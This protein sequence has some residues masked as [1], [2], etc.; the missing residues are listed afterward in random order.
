[1]IQQLAE[2]ITIHSSRLKA[3]YQAKLDMLGSLPPPIY[4]S[5]DLRNSGFKISVVDTNLFP[6]GFN[7]LCETFSE[8]ASET[9]QNYFRHWYPSTKKILIFPEEHTRNT[10]YWKN[11]FALQSILENSEFEVQIGS[12]STHFTSD[13][14]VITL[15]GDHPKNQISVRK[16]SIQDNFLRTNDFVPDI[17][18]INNDLS[19]GTPDYLKNIHQPLLPSPHLG[20]HQRRK[21]NHFSIY[22]KLITETSKIMEIDSWRLSPLF[23]METGIDLLDTICLKRLSDSAE[24]LL[25]RIRQKYLQYSIQREPYIFVKNDAGTY[26]MGIMHTTSG[27]ELLTMTSKLRRKLESAKGGLKVSNYLLQEG[28]PTADFYEK[29]PIEPV[30]YMVGGQSIGT[31]FRIHEEKNEMENLNAPGM[32]FACLCLHK[33]NASQKKYHLTCGDKEELLTISS[34]LG[35]I[36]SLAASTELKKILNPLQKKS[37]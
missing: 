16:I 23:T 33:L 3:W 9:F 5:V 34:F 35:Q 11:I 20:W 37:A 19:S 29:K 31:F 13:P 21:S 25:S 17:I 10:F 1:M 14:F 12:S 36:A 2:K 27:K 30:V 28:I 24:Q 32:S 15:D 22:E 8:K 26:G 7:N 4:S 6:A 18:L